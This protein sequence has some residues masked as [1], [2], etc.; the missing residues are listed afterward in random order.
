LFSFLFKFKRYV[1][2]INDIASPLIVVFLAEYITVDM[3]KF[4]MPDKI[5][6][7]SD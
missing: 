6:Q 4:I 5:D 7:L 1:Q 2:G 3:I